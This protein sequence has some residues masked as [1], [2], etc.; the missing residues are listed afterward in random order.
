MA[1]F[2][3]Y[4]PRDVLVQ[5]L[6]PINKLLIGL[7]LMLLIILVGNDPVFAATQLLLSIILLAASRADFRTVKPF[8]QIAAMFSVLITIS[9]SFF[10][11]G[12]DV[13]VQIG[14]FR[15]T[16]QG[17]LVI[18]TILTRILTLMFLSL[19]ILVSNSES[20]LI[21]GLRAMK[22]PY[23][24][25]FIMMLALRFVP[26]LMSDYSTIK[27]AQMARAAEFQKGSIL[28][29]AKKNVALLGPLI[30][31][32]FNRALTMSVAVESRG[33]QPS[34]LSM[35]RVNY[36]EKVFAKKDY[37]VLTSL[38]LYV[39]IVLVGHFAFG[40]LP[41]IVTTVG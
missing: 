8:L 2:T 18:A 30:V 26:T 24:G 1:D 29:R 25:T 37:V 38:V 13:L 23:V 32:S 16:Y 10:F 39:A 12:G 4:K 35:K 11:K 31:I 28:A 19:F 3:F 14:L 33:F 7:L 20:D 17:S 36:K 21:Q 15:L 22:V 5:K 6:H 40:W 34:G 27:D 41:G 9:W